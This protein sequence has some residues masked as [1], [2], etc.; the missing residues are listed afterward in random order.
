MFC[1]FL[2]NRMKEEYGVNIHISENSDIITIYGPVD[3][4]KKAQQ[5][6]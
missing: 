3:G 1:L 2:V 4:V 6:C 5:V